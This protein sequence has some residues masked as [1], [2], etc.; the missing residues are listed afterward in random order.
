MGLRHALVISGPSDPALPVDDGDWNAAHVIDDYLEFPFV[1][2][3]STPGAGKLR[4]YGMD[5]GPGAPAFKMPNGKVRLIQ[6]DLGEFNINRFQPQVGLNAFTGEHSLNTTNVGTLTA[7]AVAVTDLH[8]MTARLDLL[9]TAA[10]TT[11]IAGWRPNG[12]GSRFLRVG[13]DAN[14]PGGFLCRCMW[15]PAT[16]GTVATLRAFV[17][18]ADWSAAPTDVAPAGRT[19]IIGMGWERGVDTNIQLYCN[20]ASGTASKIDLGSGFPIPITDRPPP[21]ELQLYSPNS[22][23]R[24]VSYRVIRYASDDKVIAAEASGTLTTDLPAVTT[25]LGCVGAISVGGT[26]SVVGAAL[27]GILT[28]LEY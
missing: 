26:S 22:L 27:M 9:V 21:Y 16:G 6:N 10:A 23:T 2:E 19:N 13:K 18:L 12:A 7:A 8:R 1:A 14:A 3:P 15:A 11:A 4:L 25:L 5:F 24:S 28:A 20:D 17:G